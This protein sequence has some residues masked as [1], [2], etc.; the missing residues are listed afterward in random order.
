MA[1]YNDNDDNE[2]LDEMSEEDEILSLKTDI[3]LEI[4]M[5]EEENSTM[6]MEFPVLVNDLKKMNFNIDETDIDGVMLSLK[7][8]LLLNDFLVQETIQ[9]V[10][11]KLK[12]KKKKSVVASKN[13]ESMYKMKD[14]INSIILLL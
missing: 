7:K 3:D 13:T 4:F 14:R 10:P 6:A 8:Y 1:Y 11:K 9:E 2:I 5:T 12:L